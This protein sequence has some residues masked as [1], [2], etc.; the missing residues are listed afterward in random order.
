MKH[1]SL[2]LFGFLL[3]A[4]IACNS[5]STATVTASGVSQA[6]FAALKAEVQSLSAS[7]TALQGSVTGLASA[8]STAS[9][10]VAS[11]RI[12]GYAHNQTQVYRAS[13]VVTYA[14]SDGNPCAN[15]GVSVTDDPTTNNPGIYQSCTSYFYAVDGR[16]G[17]VSQ[18]PTIYTTPDCTGTVYVEAD[19]IGPQ[20]A[21][22]G[23]VLRDAHGGYDALPAGE[24]S[25]LIS[26][27]SLFNPA[28]GC[29]TN[30][31]TIAAYATVPN[32]AATTG[33]SNVAL[34]LPITNGPPL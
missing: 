27:G 1:W 31:P 34:A 9:A 10:R 18:V 4:I 25:A 16:T 26:E 20:A 24:A 12:F 19:S 15:L 8:S 17:L 22:Q 13:H 7:V 23:L 33:V 30:T 3:G 11:I 2:V 21:A 32:V 28:F 14:L 5:T 6:D 29:Q